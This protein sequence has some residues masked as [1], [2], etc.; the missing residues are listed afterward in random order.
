M[1]DR[2]PRVGKEESTKYVIEQYTL[3]IIHSNTS[4]S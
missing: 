4:D 3:E 1:S 2:V